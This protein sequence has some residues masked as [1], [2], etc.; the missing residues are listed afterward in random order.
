MPSR[1]HCL[2]WSEGFD[3]AEVHCGRVVFFGYGWIVFC[4]G[5]RQYYFVCLPK[6]GCLIFL[7]WFPFGSM[8]FVYSGMARIKQTAKF[9]ACG[10]FDG[11][12]TFDFGVSRVEAAELD[13]FMRSGW[14]PRDDARFCSGESTPDPP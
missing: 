14:M 2:P 7:T 3:F 11:E 6:G 4:G 13:D 5:K 12:V 9:V 8:G 1:C 10:S